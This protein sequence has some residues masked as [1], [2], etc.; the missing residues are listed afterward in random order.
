MTTIFDEWIEFCSSMLIVI[1]AIYDCIVLSRIE[2]LEIKLVFFYKLFFSSG[3][4]GGGNHIRP[5]SNRDMGDSE[6]DVRM[7]SNRVSITKPG[8][9][10]RSTFHARC[11]SLRPDHARLGNSFYCPPVGLIVYL[12]IKTIVTNRT[13]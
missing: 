13:R 6:R 7:L 5:Q 8:S 10:A 2:I 4:R 12:W 1:T 3:G 9:G 11:Q